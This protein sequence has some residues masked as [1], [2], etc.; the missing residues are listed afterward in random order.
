MSPT[1]FPDGVRP[2][3]ES[4]RIDCDT[5]VSQHTS[6]CSDCIVSYV[7]D[8]EPAGVVVDVAEF[9]ALR[10]L[11]EAGLVPGLRHVERTG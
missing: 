7:C 1:N 11:G 10:R 6:M 5:C 8:H 2:V 3:P 9:R 4:L